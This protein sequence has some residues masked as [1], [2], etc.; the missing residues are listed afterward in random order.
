[1]FLFKYKKI[2]KMGILLKTLI[3]QICNN[4]PF[5]LIA[6]HYLAKQEK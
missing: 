5:K 1:M 6:N 4:Y 2:Y 3:M